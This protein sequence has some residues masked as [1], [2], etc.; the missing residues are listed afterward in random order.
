MKSVIFY[1]SGTGNSLKIAKDISIGLKNAKLIKINSTT[2]EIVGN[3]NDFDIIGFVYPVYFLDIPKIVYDFVL[4]LNIKNNTYIF[5]VA[6]C[7]DDEGIAIHTMDKILKNKDSKLNANFV[8]KMPDNSIVYSTTDEQ[9]KAMFENQK[10]MIPYIIETINNKKD[11]TLVKKNNFKIS[12]TKKIMILVM[13][14]YF[15]YHKKSV[16]E[17]LCNKCTICVNFCPTKNITFT[18]E[19]I[20]FNSKCA[21]CFGCIHW[22]PKNAILFGKIKILNNQYH[23]PDIK[24][25]DLI[26]TGEL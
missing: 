23:H 20:K 3:L 21:D 8:L 24:L 19:K 4:N 7:G 10:Q 6:N 5:S 1:F 9:K 13:K 11:I 25:S 17:N 22:C 15:R 18:D 12:M 14:L 2:N 26:K 16:S